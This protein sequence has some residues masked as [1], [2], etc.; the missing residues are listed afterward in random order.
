[1][2]VRIDAAI[3]AGNIIPVRQDGFEVTLDR[4]LRDTGGNWFY[5]KFRAVFAVPGTYRFRF[6]G[7]AA[8]GPRGA[9][10]SRDRGLTWAWT[11]S[12]EEESFTFEYRAGDPA[13]VWFCM[14]TPY[15]QS[16]LDRFLARMAGNP[17]L[18]AETLC[19]S[20]QGRAVEKL[21][22]AEGSPEGKTHFLIA[23]RHHCCEMMATYALEGM[24]E[25]AA[26]D[27][28]FGR[29][30][31]KRFILTAIPFA[32]KDGVE[33]G[34][35]GK[36]RQPHDHA[37]DYGDA[38]IYPEVRAIMELSRSLR[39]ALTLD[40]HCP[41]LRDGCN[42]YIYLVGSEDSATE[43]KA[44]ELNGWLEKESPLFFAED[45]IPFGTS[46]NTNANYGT[47]G[48]TLAKWSRRQE[49]TRFATTFEI[50]YANCREVTLTPDLVREFG[51]TVLRT[52]Y[53]WDLR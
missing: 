13:E 28:D 32:D 22:V 19:R 11:G 6:E 50:P 10:F 53:D 14:G 35:Q 15:L 24:V 43:V 21:T 31:R 2:N 49:Y 16:D 44:R 20:P 25:K 5:W 12:R 29:S 38:P 45:F 1:M 47:G 17:Y 27:D 4:E 41:W 3:P 37:R 8:V 51:K 7:G 36:N 46:W 39:P 33:N 9:A 34:D 26:A 23:S 40:L 52:I 18:R 42:E 30:F 48:T